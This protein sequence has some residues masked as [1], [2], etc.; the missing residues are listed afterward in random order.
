MSCRQRSVSFEVPLIELK[1]DWS[2]RNFLHSKPFRLLT[3]SVKLQSV[4]DYFD[5]QKKD[6]KNIC[7]QTNNEAIDVTTAV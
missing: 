4:P 5:H 6:N 1:L 3:S 7:C 2:F